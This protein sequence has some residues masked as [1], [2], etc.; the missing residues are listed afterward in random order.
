MARV[1]LSDLEVGLIKG[2]IQHHS[3]NDQQVLSIFSFLDRSFNHREFGAI[4][5]RNKPRY[6][7]VPAASPR[8]VDELLYRYSKLAALAE[9]L[10]FYATTYAQ[11][12]VRKAIEIFETAVL[13]YNNNILSTRTETF[14][15]LSIISWTYLAHA[16]LIEE[17]VSP[18][19]K[20]A[21]GTPF[22]LMGKRNS[23]SWAT[24]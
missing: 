6:R 1:A 17:G 14:I 20:S 5:K 3:L 19:Y 11:A 16:R 24:V 8:N 18:V 12:Q 10:G 15:V 13:V 21:E 2:L 4:R 9:H 7:D 22:W 23:G